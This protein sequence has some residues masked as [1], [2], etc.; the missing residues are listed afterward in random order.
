MVAVTAEG[1]EKE[2]RRLVTEGE[3]PQAREVQEVVL[4]PAR[5]VLSSI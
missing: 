2:L 1:V 4:H 5:A 3:E